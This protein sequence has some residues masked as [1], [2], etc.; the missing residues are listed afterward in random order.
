MKLA[1]SHARILNHEYIGIEQ[2]Q[3]ALASDHQDLQ[4]TVDPSQLNQVVT[5]L[6]QNGLRYSE[7]ETGKAHLVLSVHLNPATQLT[8]LDIID[9][10]PGTPGAFVVHRR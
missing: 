1:E 4:V 6:A 5:N 8:V 2:A 7:Q 3:I 9:D 10:G